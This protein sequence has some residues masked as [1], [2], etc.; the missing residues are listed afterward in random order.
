MNIIYVSPHFPDA[1][2]GLALRLISMLLRV[3]VKTLMFLWC[4][5][6]LHQIGL[7]QGQG[8]VPQGQNLC[9][10]VREDI[11]RGSS[12]LSHSKHASVIKFSLKLSGL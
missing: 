5:L 4:Q 1:A 9:L 2:S 11:M 6:P 8:Q 3:A 12:L 7:P 10:S